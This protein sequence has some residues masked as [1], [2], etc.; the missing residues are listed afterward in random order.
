MRLVKEP[1][2]AWRLQL[3]RYLEAQNEVP[4][5]KWGLV[6]ATYLTGN[7]S[8]A[9][10]NAVSQ[11]SEFPA[12]WD[13]FD[14]LMTSLQLGPP[15]TLFGL[16][17]QLTSAGP[18]R[19]GDGQPSTAQLVQSL[20]ASFVEI[21]RL[22]GGVPTWDQ[23]QIWVTLQ[24]IRSPELRALAATQGGKEWTSWAAFR[25]HLVAVGTASETAGQLDPAPRRQ[26]QQQQRQRQRQRQRM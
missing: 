25:Q 26:Q 16:W 5:D 21:S 9:F 12:G 6:A 22:A 4:K 15:V 19:G 17:Q 1:Y 8:M 10:E 3:R 11:L 2:S 20:E 14:S 7:A 23:V 18:K 13:A 24:A